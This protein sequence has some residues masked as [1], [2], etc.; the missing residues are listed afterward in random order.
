MKEWGQRSGAGAGSIMV[1]V[2][3]VLVLALCPDGKDPGEGVIGESNGWG[4]V[5]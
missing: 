4:W 5:S 1:R 2:F 3:W